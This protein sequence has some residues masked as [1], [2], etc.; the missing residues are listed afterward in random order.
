MSYIVILCTLWGDCASQPYA[1]YTRIEPCKALAVVLKGRL[2]A[3]HP[4]EPLCRRG[5]WMPDE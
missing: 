1:V 2:P 5:W 3:A 4:H